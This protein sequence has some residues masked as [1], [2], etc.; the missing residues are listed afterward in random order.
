MLLAYKKQPIIEKRFS[1]F[2]SDFHV[3]S[4]YLK[5]VSR[6]EGLLCVYFVAMLAQALLEREIRTLMSD[7]KVPALPIYPEGR[8]CKA[9]CSR[10]ILDLFDNIQRHV[11]VE[12][13]KGTRTLLTALAPV[14]EQVLDLLGLR[15]SYFK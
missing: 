2:K 14:Q 12:K 15:A 5:S 8:S 11:L 7:K 1:Q 13:G 9:P 4:I 6:I 10:R 3:A